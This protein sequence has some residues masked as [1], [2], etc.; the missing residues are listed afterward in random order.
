MIVLLVMIQVFYCTNTPEYTNNSLLNGE[1]H[2]RLVPPTGAN[3][4]I[5][6]HK[7]YNKANLCDLQYNCHMYGSQELFFVFLITMP[8][9]ISHIHK[10]DGFILN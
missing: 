10:L 9:G 3:I 8:N 7:L 5:Y 1:T 6:T 4:C 2:L